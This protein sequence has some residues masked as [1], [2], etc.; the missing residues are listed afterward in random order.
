MI[1]KSANFRSSKIRLVAAAAKPR[2]DKRRTDDI[3]ESF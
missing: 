3:A 1:R 2:F